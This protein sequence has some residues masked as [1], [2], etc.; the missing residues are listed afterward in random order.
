[1]LDEDPST[2]LDNKDNLDLFELGPDFLNIDYP[3]P[4]QM[5][6]DEEEG[7]GFGALEVD[8]NIAPTSFNVDDYMVPL[9]G[10]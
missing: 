9:S 3:V 8:N 4:E 2:S 6:S 7:N 5:T 10:K 1:M